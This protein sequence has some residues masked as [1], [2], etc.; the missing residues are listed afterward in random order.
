LHHQGTL[1]PGQWNVLDPCF[2]QINCKG[3][4][5]SGAAGANFT[6]LEA[7]LSPSNDNLRLLVFV[8]STAAMGATSTAAVAAGSTAAAWG[9]ATAA[10]A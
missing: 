9:T 1:K 8:G 5:R 10:V 6:F 4:Y 3:R 7:S 2:S